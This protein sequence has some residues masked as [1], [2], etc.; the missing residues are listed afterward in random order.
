[1]QAR[2]ENLPSSARSSLVLASLAQFEHSL[3]RPNVSHCVLV[4]VNTLVP[5]FLMLLPVSLCLLHIFVHF[6]VPDN[7]A[8]G[9]LKKTNNVSLLIAIAATLKLTLDCAPILE[10]APVCPALAPPALEA[11][12][13]VSAIMSRSSSKVSAYHSSNSLMSFDFWL[14]MACWVKRISF[15]SSLSS[16]KFSRYC[17]FNSLSSR[18]RCS[19]SSS[20]ISAC[21]AAPVSSNPSVCDVMPGWSDC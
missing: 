20:I 14:S 9:S 21:S 18:S 5:V 16:M 8:R 3:A 1:M 17:F 15:C 11:A 10:A 19:S 2:I 6:W 4:D 7:L 13:L 12:T